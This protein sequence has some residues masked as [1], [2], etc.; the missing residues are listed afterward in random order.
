MPLCQ[1]SMFSAPSWHLG[2][3][4]TW[5]FV[6]SL[7][8][9]AG[10][11]QSQGS[12]VL[13][14]QTAPQPSS[15]IVSITQTTFTPPSRRAQPRQTIGGGSRDGGICPQDIADADATAVQVVNSP[16]APDAPIS[17]QIPKTLART[18]ELS[19]FDAEGKGVYQTTLD[20]PPTPAVL[21]LSLPPEMTLQP[22]ATYQWVF[23]LVCSPND[24]FQ[25]RTVSGW[26]QPAS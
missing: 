14:S 24:R 13:A 26:I 10:A 20:L 17:L 8:S 16:D 15:Q 19:L 22:G 3:A 12:A 21:Q 5:V 11:S 6:L 4:V 9:T 23:A 1:P 25:D 2:I 7:G 18:G